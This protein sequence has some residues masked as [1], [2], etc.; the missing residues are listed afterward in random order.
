MSPLDT[1]EKNLFFNFERYDL[2]NGKE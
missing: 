2:V 1:G